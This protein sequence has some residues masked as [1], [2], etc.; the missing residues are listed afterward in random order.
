MDKMV[1]NLPTLP[2]KPILGHYYLLKSNSAEEIFRKAMN[3][4]TQM[5][6]TFRVWFG[7]WLGVI[8]QDKDDLRAVF[9]CCEKSFLYQFM[10]EFAHDGLVILNGE[11]LTCEFH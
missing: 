1:V 6:C 3:M 7:P 2:S 9:K 11:L 5:D 10:P 8:V 4:A